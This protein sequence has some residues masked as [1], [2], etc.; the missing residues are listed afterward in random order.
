MIKIGIVYIDCPK[1]MKGTR[2]SSY[3]YFIGDESLLTNSV[4]NNRKVFD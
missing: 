1:V 2:L 3:R 4:V